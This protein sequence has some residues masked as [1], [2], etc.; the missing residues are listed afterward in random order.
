MAV[1]GG[2]D[3]VRCDERAATDVPE[4]GRRFLEVQ[5]D[6]PGVVVAVQDSVGDGLG[7]DGD[8]EGCGT[9]GRC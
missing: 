9:Q 3:L 6:H 4:A 2:D 5:Q 8:G 1:A 7:G